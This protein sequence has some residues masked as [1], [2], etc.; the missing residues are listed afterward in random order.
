MSEYAFDPSNVVIKKGSTI[1]VENAGSIGHNLTIEQGPD[2]KK[3]TKRLAGTPTFLPDKTK[4][5]K[6]NL[7]PGK[8]AMVCTV[9]GHRQLGMVGTIT[10]K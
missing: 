9:A 6:V 7:A 1:K 8:Y 4:R 2:P 10:V 3:A 5:L